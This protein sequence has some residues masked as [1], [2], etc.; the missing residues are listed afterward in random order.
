MVSLTKRLL[1]SMGYP[2]IFADQA[3]FD[4]SPNKVPF[5]S[6]LLLRVLHVRLMYFRVC[7]IK[8]FFL[9]FRYL[10]HSLSQ[11]FSL[12][13]WEF[14]KADVD[15]TFHKLLFLKKTNLCFLLPQ[16]LEK[17]FAYES[18]YLKIYLNTSADN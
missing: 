15:C 10:E 2:I 7:K 12:L 4:F 18:K 8:K 6:I 5:V 14:E 16:R 17:T 9:I 13:P 1:Q 11:T 3:I